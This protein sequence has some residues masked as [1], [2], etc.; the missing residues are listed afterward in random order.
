MI[1]LINTYW[2]PVV[3]LFVIFFDELFNSAAILGGF[4]VESGI[5][6]YEAILLA[7]IGYSVLTYNLL[8]RRIKKRDHQVIVVLFSLLLLYML[9]PVFYNGS[10]NDYTAYLL[11]YGAESIPAAI[12]GMKL[13][14]SSN[15][16]IIN[17]LLPFFVIPISILVGTIGLTAAMMGTTVG[18]YDYQEGGDTGLNYQTLSYF[19]AFSYTYAFYYAFYGNLKHGIVNLLLR[20]AMVAD[21]LFCLAVCMMGGGRGGFVYIIAITLFLM[22]YYLKSSKKHRVHAIISIIILVLVGIYIIISMDVMQSVGMTRIT[23]RL[24]GDN[25]RMELYQKA[26]DAFITSPII[27]KGVG[28]IW[29]TVGFY[30]HNIILDLLAETGLIGTIFLLNIVLQS[31]KKLYRLSNSDKIYLFILLIIAGNF[32]NCMFSGYYIGAVKV[33]FVCSFVYCLP[34]YKLKSKE[35]YR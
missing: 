16:H 21:M 20:V 23:G 19:M 29:W 4:T 3:A 8:N 25:A 1:K 31:F 24:G 12:I 6:K 35:I 27:G 14:K 33:Y 32:I 15:L 9:T 7:A 2:L 34:K 13:A 17:D 26:F 11:V 28:S 5:K 30:C 18:K 22:F 10:N